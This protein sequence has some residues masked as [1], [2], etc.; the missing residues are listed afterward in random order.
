MLSTLV[1]FVLLLKSRIVI[2]RLTL[3]HSCVTLSL[4]LSYLPRLRYYSTPVM[5]G[6]GVCRSLLDAS[7]IRC[8]GYFV[9]E[10]R[11]SLI[12]PDREHV[13]RDLE[14]CRRETGFRPICTERIMTVSSFALS[15]SSLGKKGFGRKMLIT[16]QIFE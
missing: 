2:F 1:R 9:I 12:D 6:Q 10:T 4:A 15:L 5:T 16:N 13:E 7:R 3:L 11:N 8:Y 14:C